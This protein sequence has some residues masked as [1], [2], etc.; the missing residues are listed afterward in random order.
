MRRLPA[1]FALCLGLAGGLPGEAQANLIYVLNSG[2]ASIS[3]GDATPREEVRR[4]PVLRE[5]PPLRLTP[6]RSELVAGDSGGNELI[7]IAPA[8][9]EVTRRE[10]FSNPYHMEYSP[11][12]R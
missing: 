6:D 12:G 8:T 5:V 4:I 9:A 2:D 7:F 1:A 3:L 11:D 10:R